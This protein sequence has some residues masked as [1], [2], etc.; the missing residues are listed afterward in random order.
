[1]VDNGRGFDP[2]ELTEAQCLGLVGMRERA[3]LLGGSLEMRSQPGAGTQV[4]FR[5]PLKGRKE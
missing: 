3:G 5:L 4:Y 1:V 2:R